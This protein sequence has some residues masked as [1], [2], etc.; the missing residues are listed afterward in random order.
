MSK[1]RRSSSSKKPTQESF[2]YPEDRDQWLIDLIEI[3]E[4]VVIAYER[5][6]LDELN[7]QDLSKVMTMLRKT[8]PMKNKK[9]RS[10]KNT[11]SEE[12]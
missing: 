6:L 10:Y 7:Y 2:V 9:P 1:R 12:D 11:E 5:Y 4:A 3:S 8:L